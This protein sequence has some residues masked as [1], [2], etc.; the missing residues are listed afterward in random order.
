MSES[1]VSH[2]F[3][4]FFFFPVFCFIIG[5]PLL[6]GWRC[7]C[8]VRGAKKP[9]RLSLDKRIIFFFLLS[10]LLLHLFLVLRDFCWEQRGGWNK[11]RSWCWFGESNQAK[12]QRILPK[13]SS[14]RLLAKRRR[15][16]GRGEDLDEDGGLCCSVEKGPGC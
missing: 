7:D 10:L 16:R 14:R 13:L 6:S 1:V 12:E 5:A 9:A 8:Q 15:S 11:R 3:L 4:I 2:F